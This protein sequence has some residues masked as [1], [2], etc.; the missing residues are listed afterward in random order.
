MTFVRASAALVGAVFLFL[1]AG[2][3]ASG[4]EDTVEV[5]VPELSPLAQLG[6]FAFGQHCAHC[7]GDNGAGSGKGPPLVH[8]IYEPHHHADAAFMRAIRF[9]SRAHHWRFG[10]MPAQKQVSDEEARAIIEFVREV[11]RANGI[12]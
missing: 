2:A 9:G 3:G 11:Q 8:R 10:D 7:H 4:A 5:T 12:E 1:T 6:Q